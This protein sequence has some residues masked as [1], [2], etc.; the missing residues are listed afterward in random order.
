ML[1]I[2]TLNGCTALRSL[3]IGYHPSSLAASDLP[4]FTAFLAGTQCPPSNIHLDIR[5]RTVYCQQ[6]ITCHWPWSLLDATMTSPQFSSLESFVLHFHQLSCTLDM[7]PVYHDICE[8][9]ASQLPGLISRGILYVC[10]ERKED[11]DEVE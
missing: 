7:P 6:I 11:H 9:L 3:R 8:D 2:L 10:A 4:V 1:G 5:F